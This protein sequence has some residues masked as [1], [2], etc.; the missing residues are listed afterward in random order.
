MNFPQYLWLAVY[1]VL[2]GVSHESRSKSCDLFI[3]IRWFSSVE[4]VKHSLTKTSSPHNINKQLEIT[5]PVI[6]LVHTMPHD[7]TLFNAH[8][9]IVMS[10]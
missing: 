2:G 4:G 9:A 5:T 7:I 1:A 3:C 10:S 6:M 8:G